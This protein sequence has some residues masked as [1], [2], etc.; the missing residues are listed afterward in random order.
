M[1]L[2]LLA[3]GWSAPASA[4]PNR[5]EQLRAGDLRVAIVAYRLSIA[6][7]QLCDR[8]LAPQF[9]FVLHGVEQYAP[10]DRDEAARSFGLGRQIGV[11]A[12][13]PGSPAG[14]AGLT[15]GDHLLS[16]NGREL[17][18]EAP[19][20]SRARARVE[21]AQ[22]VLEQEM[23]R[24]PVTLR[25][26]ARGSVRD[27]RFA[28][29]SGC[30]S[31]VELIPGDAMNAWADGVR[32]IVSDGLLARCATDDLLALVIGHEMAHNLLR[33]RQRRA[34]VGTSTNSLLPGSDGASRERRETEEEADRLA[35]SLAMAAAYDLAGVEPLLRE[36]LERA[37]L[38]ATHPGPDQRLALLRAAIV[39]AKRGRGPQALPLGQ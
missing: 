13:V 4:A 35:V 1:L 7:R 3:L 12:V 38:A 25:V 17:G 15:A 37:P 18:G 26:S 2:A 21:R 8:I 19:V 11:M 14:S 6:N 5:F 33:H 22:Q 16:V 9:G 36:L 30:P 31:N 29:E 20:G 27:L 39:D 10:S 34:A 32:V 23:R 28:A 24:G